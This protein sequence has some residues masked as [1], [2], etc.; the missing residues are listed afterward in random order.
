M[1]LTRAGEVKQWLISTTNYLSPLHTRVAGSGVQVPFTV[2]PSDV[3]F[4]FILPAGTYPRAHMKN[5]SAPSRVLWYISMKPFRGPVGI[6]QLTGGRDSNRIL[7]GM[8]K[9]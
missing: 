5:I 6:P 7:R 9:C 2:I 4:A 8:V 3:Q 1:V